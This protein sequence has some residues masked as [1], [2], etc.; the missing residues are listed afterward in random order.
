M[1]LNFTITN[2]KS[3]NAIYKTLKDKVIFL[4]KVSKLIIMKEPNENNNKLI[5][6]KNT[7]L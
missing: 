4:D 7:K 5:S 6:E 1:Q 3:Q 2:A